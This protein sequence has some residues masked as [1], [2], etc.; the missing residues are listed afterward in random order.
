MNPNEFNEG[1]SDYILL[2]HMFP[3][4]ASI[5]YPTIL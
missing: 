5:I 1:K 2:E 3:S 4:N